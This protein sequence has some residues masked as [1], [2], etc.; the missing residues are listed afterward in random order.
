VLSNLSAGY[1]VASFKASQSRDD[2]L[3]TGQTLVH[4]ARDPLRPLAIWLQAARCA[5]CLNQSRA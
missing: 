5:A 3:Q 1:T 4:V 2:T